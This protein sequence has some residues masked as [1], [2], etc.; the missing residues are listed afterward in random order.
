MVKFVALFLA[1]ATSL[2][3]IEVNHS[4]KIDEIISKDLTNKKIAMPEKASN[5]VFVR[6]AY[7]DI[8]GRIPSFE[9]RDAFLKDPNKEQLI[10][11]LVDSQGYVESTF[12]FYADLLRVKRKILN[13]VTGE[14]YIAWIKDEIKKNTPYDQF[15]KSILTAEGTIFTNPAVGY[16]LRDEG[17]LLD[18]VSNTFQ[19]FAGMN[20]SCAQCHD[21]PFDDWTQMDYYE[22]TAFFTT[23]DTR[24]K[25]EDNKHYQ[26]LRKQCEELDKSGKEKGSQ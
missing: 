17:M 23:V 5:E 15:V 14:T 10:N 4:L 1:L 22:M 9:E 3:S 7:L 24:A 12:N 25:K 19:A 6:R 2:L 21:H 13:N 18:N 20:I 8:V 11:K 16:F 26:D